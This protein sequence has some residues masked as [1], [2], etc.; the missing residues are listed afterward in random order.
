MIFRENSVTT[1]NG[2]NKNEIFV[3]TVA[4]TYFN[5]TDLEAWQN[6]QIASYVELQDGVTAKDLAAPIQQLLQQNT[7]AI[8][9]QNLVV[10]PILL[11]D[12]Y[13]QKDNALVKRMLYALSF[14][15]LFILLMAVV[16]FINIAISGGSNRMKE[17]GVR[18]VMGGMRS[19]LIIQFLTESL[20]LVLIAT[21]VA[22]AIYPIVEPLF[23][24]MVGKPL[25]ALLSLPVYFIFIVATFIILLGLLA[26][27]YPAF[28]LSAVNT[29]YSLKGKLKT[30]KE[31]IL[32]RKSLVGFQFCIA[33]VVLIGATIVTQ[34][35]AYFFGQG[36]GYNKEYIVASQVPRDW[37]PAGVRKMETV[38]N[39]FAAM[40]QV[41][42]VTL[43]YEIPNGMNGG[44]PPVYKFG[45][46]STQAIAMDALVTDEN[47]LNTYQ[48]PLQSGEFFD[49]K[50]LDS[51]K[52]VL[53]E[54][55]A[56]AL[57]YKDAA[58]AIGEAVRIPGDP[59]L[60]TVK[61]V[62]TDFHFGSMQQAIPPMIV[63]NLANATNYRYLSFKLKPGNISGT[64]EAIQKKWATLLPGTS[65]DYVFM[66]DA[67][68]KIYKS[69]LQ[70][71]KAAYT[72]TVLSIIIVLMGVLGLVSLSV[73]KRTK[74]IG[75]RKVLGS[76]VNGI[77]IL[78]LKDFLKVI[79]VAGIIS[80][81]IAWFIMHGWL[82]DYAYRINLTATPFII[83]IT[84]LVLVT[85]IL[86]VLQT[87]KTGTE[88]PVKSLRTE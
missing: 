62:T 33:L 17:I 28:V 43:S 49:S 88:N 5:R 18:K 38:R 69:E 10:K 29:I 65:F 19:Q 40:P 1:L 32:L 27:I 14:I 4:Y 13:L 63:F 8:T 6:I 58:T 86:I 26:G 79:I 64:I 34:Q 47:Y 81:P 51:G 48:I 76:S 22:V 60:Y 52:V 72:A 84:G 35:V 39:E 53:N 80:C 31:N 15:G 68:K 16:N 87:I 70:L 50:G 20:I 57:G 3:P 75:I 9:Q 83:C 25:P 44:Q 85:T 41:A 74:E 30:V 59:T 46:D 71:Q 54:K 42:N 11:T 61:G 7:S 12:Y 56:T 55:A 23:S 73:Q 21:L 37:T 82:S 36:L 77:I 66:D 2:E 24:Q 78:F 45:T 67:L